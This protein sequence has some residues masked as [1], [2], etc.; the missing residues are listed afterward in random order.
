MTVS[1]PATYDNLKRE[2]ELEA[3]RPDYI[4]TV[5]EAGQTVVKCHR[6]LGA[7]SLAGLIDHLK[8][9]VAA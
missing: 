7:E 5:D 8:R 4:I 2:R 1:W 3:A 6:P 9:L